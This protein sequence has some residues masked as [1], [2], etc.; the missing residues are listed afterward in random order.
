MAPR[1]HLARKSEVDLKVKAEILVYSGMV[2]TQNLLERGAF[3]MFIL[4]VSFS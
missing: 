4:N 1:I 2:I 3:S